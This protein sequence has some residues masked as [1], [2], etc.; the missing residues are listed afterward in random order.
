MTN[1]LLTHTHTDTDTVGLPAPDFKVICLY[2]SCAL[3]PVPPSPR[4]PVASPY[5]C[6]SLCFCYL[7]VRCC[8]CCC[9]CSL[10]A[11]ALKHLTLS[12]LS[13]LECRPDILFVCVFNVFLFCCPHN[14][15]AYTHTR[16]H[17]QPNTQYWLQ[18]QL[19]AV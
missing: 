9:C 14:Y 1:D 3:C 12:L 18:Q 13:Q 17:T 11:A 6:C 4:S 15:A 2:V 16:T 8:C 10:W 5:S 7:L 19:G